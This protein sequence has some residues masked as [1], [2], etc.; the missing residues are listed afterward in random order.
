MSINDVIRDKDGFIRLIYHPNIKGRPCG[1]IKKLMEAQERKFGLTGTPIGETIGKSRIYSNDKLPTIMNK[2]EICIPRTSTYSI[3][4]GDKSWQ[5]KAWKELANVYDPSTPPLFTEGSARLQHLKGIS[6]S[7]KVRV[8]SN[9]SRKDDVVI[10]RLYNVSGYVRAT[11]RN[12]II[13]LL[14]ELLDMVSPAMIEKYQRKTAAM[15]YDAAKIKARVLLV[16]DD[17]SY[18]SY[19]GSPLYLFNILGLDFED[20]KVKL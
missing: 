7:A 16:Y 11:T 13:N 2:R 19:I 8:V 14:D 3:C 12:D 4:S 20:G 17:M 1:I 5:F 9:N 18:D 15:R 10:Y 6:I